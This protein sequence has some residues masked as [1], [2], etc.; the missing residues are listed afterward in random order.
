MS[1]K[2]AN[3]RP[4]GLEDASILGLPCKASP[5]G[6]FLITEDTY[7]VHY[8]LHIYVCVENNKMNSLGLNFL[9]FEL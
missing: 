4:F 7:S 3:S 9:V 2:G 8:V 5:F 6:L 1:S